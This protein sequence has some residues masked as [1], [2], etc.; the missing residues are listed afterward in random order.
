VTPYP[1]T[2]TPRLSA[3][4]L[5]FSAGPGAL[6]QA[7]LD[8]TQ[9][10]ILEVA[11]QGLSILGISHRTPWFR[12][13]VD[14]AEENIRRLLAL[15]PGF[16]VLFLQGGSSLQFGMI[17]QAL[18]HTPHASADYLVTGYWSTKSIEDVSRFGRLNVLWNG[19]PTGFRTLPAAASLNPH[20][21]ATYF[22]YVSNETVEG[23]QFR[24]IPGLDGVPRICDMSSDFLSAPIDADRFSLIYAHAQKNLGPAGVTVVLIHDDLLARCR[25]DV[26]AMLDFHRHV[27]A[28]SIYN[29]PP[30]FAIYVLLL[31]TRWLRHDIGGL[32]AMAAINRAKTECL[33]AVFDSDTDFWRLHADRSSQSVMN[34]ALRL[35]TAALEAQFLEAAREAGFSGLEGHR[36]VGGLRVSL[37]NGVTLAAVQT[38]ADFLRQ[39]RA[40]SR[41]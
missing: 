27:E 32:Q 33:A 3:N 8:Q 36:S 31:I 5:N 34:I 29:T 23:L 10:A 30:V 39:F 40:A 22:H 21:Q 13:V 35:P 9:Q 12:D 6:P 16:Q 20:P 41:G 26:P 25:R 28:R 38:L 1:T 15:P 37:Y 18:L 2:L 4:E 14:E 19:A 11:G 17:P 7:V 24:E